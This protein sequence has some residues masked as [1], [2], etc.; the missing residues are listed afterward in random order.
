[1]RDTTPAPAHH[2]D[3]LQTRLG[4]SHALR[5]A[6]ALILAIFTW[7]WVMQAADPIT[8]IEHSELEITMPPLPDGLV[9]VTNLPKGAIKVE[10][11]RSE[12]SRTNRSTLSLSLDVSQVTRAGEYRLPVVIHAPDTSTRNRVSPQYVQ[13]QI[14]E[15]TSKT[16]PLEVERPE[17]DNGTRQVNSVRPEVSQVTVSGPSIA[18]ARV[19]RVVLPIMLD[20]QTGS[21]TASIEPVPIDEHGQP[22]TEVSVLPAK[23]PTRIEVQSRGKVVSV[24]ANVTGMPADGYTT[25]QKDALPRNITV[26]GP[27]E[28]LQGLLFVNT[29]PVD[30]SGASQS[31]SEKV[32]LADLPAGVTIVDPPNG[33]VEVRVAI[34][35]STST[36]QTVSDLPVNAINVRSGL[37]V[38][39]EPTSVNVVVQGPVTVIQSMTEKDINVIVDVRD[40]GPGEYELTPF[41]ALSNPVV[42]AEGTNPGTVL[43]TLTEPVESTPVDPTAPRPLNHQNHPAA[44]QRRRTGTT[45]APLR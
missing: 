35:D 1:M 42:R 34:Q 16:L 24:I 9:S 45:G 28:T 10:G 17:S 30:I 41:V 14:D 5:L 36:S 26:E 7:G 18:V 13:V 3:S 2:V 44:R 6:T 43:V 22:V 12:V 21:F 8:Q 29:E 4:R 27:P 20:S 19:E 31:V 39:I 38:T 15:I 11:P 33:L 23:I 37:E 40:L 32:G 25:Q